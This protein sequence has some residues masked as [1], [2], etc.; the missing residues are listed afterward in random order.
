MNEHRL[1]DRSCQSSGLSQRGQGV[2][3]EAEDTGY[4]VAGVGVVAH[5]H[6]RRFPVLLEP[7]TPGLAPVLTPCTPIALLLCP[8]TP[9]VWLLVPYTNLRRRITPKPC[10]HVRDAAGP[11]RLPENTGRVHGLAYRVAKNTIA[12]T[13]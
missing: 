3:S 8:Y 13:C 7:C 2:G 6:T 9:T 10:H 1:P 4:V 12:L 5:P 11:A